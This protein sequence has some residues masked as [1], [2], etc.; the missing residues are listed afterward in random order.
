MNIDTISK[1]QIKEFLDDN[2]FAGVF[3]LYALSQVLH[4]KLFSMVRPTSVIA[5]LK[6]TA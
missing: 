4:S 3:S 5:V 2:D 1:N 6:L